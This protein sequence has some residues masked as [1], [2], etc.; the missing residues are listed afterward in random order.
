[1]Q[2][3]PDGEFL[4]EI[5]FSEDQGCAIVPELTLRSIGFHDVEERVIGRV[6]PLMVE[7]QATEPLMAK[8]V[9]RDEKFGS[10]PKTYIRTTID[11]G[12]SSA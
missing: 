1:M 12:A 6:L 8:V 5:I 7:Q 10:V 9:V 2:S 4:P 3:D 11:K